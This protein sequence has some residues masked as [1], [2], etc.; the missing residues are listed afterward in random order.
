[1]TD[2]L[3]E[4][5]QDL[6]TARATTAALLV[7]KQR[8]DDF[9]LSLVHEFRNPLT[10][11]TGALDIL[12]DSLAD[13]VNPKEHEFFDIMDVSLA[14][15]N[16]M[17]DEMLEVTALE[18]GEVALNYEPTDIAAL[19]QD[20]LT[21]FEPRAKIYDV[22]LND[23]ESRDAAKVE[24]DAERIRRVLANLISN[25]VKYNRPG[26][27]VT[28]TLERRGDFLHIAVADTGTGIPKEDHGKVFRRFYRAAEVRDNKIV[29]TGL[30]LAIAKNIVDMHGGEISFSSENGVGTTFSFTLPFTRP[31]ILRRPREKA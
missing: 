9:L 15:L 30:G 14:R 4:C 18:G 19:V 6:D 27:E 31:K 2:D 22:K 28:V 17:L 23:V 21:E 26:G 10:A 24:C 8:R 16:Q 25:A 20:V 11:L 29:G 12:K 3:K 1:M 7:E 13:R 5:R